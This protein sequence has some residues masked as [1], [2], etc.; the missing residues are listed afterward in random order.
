MRAADFA[1][2]LESLGGV[3]CDA[4]HVEDLRTFFAARASNV[5]GGAHAVAKAIDVMSACAAAADA[6]R[7][8][9]AEFLKGL[10]RS[11]P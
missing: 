3:Y 2:L 10:S 8:S 1:P 11:K 7:K 4:A 6:D 5:D 9:I